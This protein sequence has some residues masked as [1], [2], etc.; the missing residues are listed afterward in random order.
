MHVE[1][2]M[3]KKEV[4][5]DLKGQAAWTSVISL[6]KQRKWS[7]KSISEKRTKEKGTQ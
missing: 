7:N 6:K 2:R 5:R 4:K 3:H 1:E